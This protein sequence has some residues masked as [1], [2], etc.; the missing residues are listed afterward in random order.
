MVAEYFDTLYGPAM[1]AADRF[2]RDGFADSRELAGFLHEMRRLWND[3][4]VENVRADEFEKIEVG[5][6]LKITAEV[7]TCGFPADRFA[8]EIYHGPIDAAGQI[9][10]PQIA[11]M[12]PAGA[13]SSGAQSFIGEINCN[14]SGQHG[15]SIRVLP[16]HP[17]QTRRFEPGLIRWG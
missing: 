13:A 9:I 4:R 16:K 17:K 11:A 3:V 2:R 6:S 14:R 15:Y 10:Q 5:R 12:T 1:N 8:V 7:K